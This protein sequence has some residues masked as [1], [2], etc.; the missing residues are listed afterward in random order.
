[1]PLLEGDVELPE[2]LPV[3]APLDGAVVLAPDPAA[4]APVSVV[5]VFEDPLIVFVDPPEVPAGELADAPELFAGADELE[6]PVVA[7]RSAERVQPTR[8]NEATAANTIIE[9]RTGFI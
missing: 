6:V 5:P 1:M 9:F 7:L 2:V 3:V 8:L 4:A